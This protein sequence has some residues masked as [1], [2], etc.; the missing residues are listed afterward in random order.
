MFQQGTTGGLT[1]DEKRIVKYLITQGWT[2]QNIQA[3]IN[4]ERP[5]TINFGRIAGVKNDDTVIPCDEKEFH[6]YE[7]FKRSFDL[8]TGLNPFCDE[9]LIKSREA[10]KLAVSVF[11][12]PSF[13]FRA[14]SFSMLANVAWTYLILE[15]SARN[16]LPLER[17]GGKAISLSDF[18]N[19]PNCPFSSGV[20]DNLRALIKIR[21]ATEH[22]VL[23]PYDDAWIRI[24]QASCLNYENQIV[25]IFG[26]RASIASEVSFALQFSGLKIG[27]ALEMVKA[28]VPDK[29]KSINSE[30]FGQM[31]QEQRDNLEFQ[32]TVVYTTIESS[33]SKAA[34]QFVSPKTAEGKEISNVLVKHKPSEITHP[35]KPTEVKN[36]IEHRSGKKFTM[37]Q[38]TDAWRKHRVRPEGRSLEPEKTNLDYC[39]Y[40]PTFDAYT[41]NEAWVEL[42]LKDL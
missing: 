39:Y 18:L 5:A 22:V 15:Y 41:Y 11:N 27:Q 42:L 14:E 25:Q 26:E 7:K 12:N 17:K 37:Q 23:G 20:V 2:N 3:L 9:R 38:H 10:M 32:F 28:D 21:D 36:I 16:N 6:S 33:K 8:R 19:G 4:L 40:N 34:I 31:T 29:V 35:Y 1:E 30:I 13:Q 24:F